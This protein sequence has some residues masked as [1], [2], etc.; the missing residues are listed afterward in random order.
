MR[1][2]R[3]RRERGEEGG[4]VS[5]PQQFSKVGAYA[6][7][8]GRRALLT[9]CWGVCTPFIIRS[10]KRLHRASPSAVCNPIFVDVNLHY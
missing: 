5:P 10:S 9:H 4:E 2:R 8:T 3:R 1:G 6:Q 7:I